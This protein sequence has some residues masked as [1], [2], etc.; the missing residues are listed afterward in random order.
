MTSG[1]ENRFFHFFVRIR[2]SPALDVGVKLCLGR[3]KTRDCNTCR[4]GISWVG[5]AKELVN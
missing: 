2:I 1:V 5:I 4:P 3:P